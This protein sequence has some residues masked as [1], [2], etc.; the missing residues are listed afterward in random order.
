MGEQHNFFINDE[1]APEHLVKPADA[2][3]WEGDVFHFVPPVMLLGKDAA[4][5]RVTQEME[6]LDLS[7]AELEPGVHRNDVV[8]AFLNPRPSDE[9][10]NFIAT[11]Q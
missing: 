5:N 1:P 2:G 4:G 9:G 10:G 11:R 7:T 3:H 6:Q 8:S